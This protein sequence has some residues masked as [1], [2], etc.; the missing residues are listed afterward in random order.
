[1]NITAREPHQPCT[2]PCTHTHST[3]TAITHARTTTRTTKERANERMQAAANAHTDINNNTKGKLSR[4]DERRAHTHRNREK[5]AQAD[6]QTTQ[7]FRR[8]EGLQTSQDVTTRYAHPTPRSRRARSGN[9]H[10]HTTTTWTTLGCTHVHGHACRHVCV[11]ER[12]RL[13]FLE[14]RAHV[15]TTERASTHT[16]TQRSTGTTDSVNKRIKACGHK[17]GKEMQ[18]RPTPHT[19][20]RRPSL[21]Q[22]HPPHKKKPAQDSIRRKMLS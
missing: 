17:Q 4:T 13:G 22:Q 9:T 8:R 12:V 11:H 15:N 2:S 5:Q 1:M 21:G 3:A 7:W 10:R 14:R 6:G 19:P 18:Y 16:H 20:P